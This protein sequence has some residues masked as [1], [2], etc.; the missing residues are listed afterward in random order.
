MLTQFVIMRMDKNKAF[1]GLHLSYCTDCCSRHCVSCDPQVVNAAETTRSD[2]TAF[3]T[4]GDK[5]GHID[6]KNFT[7]GNED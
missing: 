1:D 3:P 6:Y 5:D 2:D 4:D 7:T